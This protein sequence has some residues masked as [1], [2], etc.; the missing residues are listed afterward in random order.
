MIMDGLK[1][2]HLTY[3]RDIRDWFRAVKKGIPVL[4]AAV[5]LGVLAGYGIGAIL[6]GP[7]YEAAA[8][9][10]I[11]KSQDADADSSAQV[12]VHLTGALAE[13]KQERR[14][15][16]EQ[17]IVSDA[18]AQA[19]ISA[20]Q[21]KVDGVPM[22][23]GRLLGMVSIDPVRSTE[24]PSASSVSGIDDDTDVQTVS[25]RVRDTDAKRTAAIA[26]LLREAAAQIVTA[27]RNDIAIFPFSSEP[28]TAVYIGPNVALFMVIGG[29]AAFVLALVFITFRF[30]GD[31]TLRT[32]EDIARC[33]GIETLG[34]IPYVKS[35]AEIGGSALPGKPGGK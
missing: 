32:Q 29:L 13:E 18:A 27:Q 22:E 20:L 4:I 8:S 30:L 26:R 23:T 7:K 6:I 34:T 31:D 12:V 10:D 28:V 14:L 5:I 21:I 25:F 35:E 17:A 2:T 24:K 9:M 3:K 15:F 1:Q 16:C 11:T 33:L 19:V